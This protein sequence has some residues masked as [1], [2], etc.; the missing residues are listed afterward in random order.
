MASHLPGEARRIVVSAR[1]DPAVVKQVRAVEG[2]SFS[3][4]VEQ[5][6]RLWLEQQPKPKRN[7]RRKV[8]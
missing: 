2:V 8:S 5:G 6:L 1:L 3:H 7:A 4:A